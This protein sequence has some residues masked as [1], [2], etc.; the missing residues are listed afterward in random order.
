MYQLVQDVIAYPEFLS[1]C[2]GAEVLEQTSGVQIARL[3]V[4]IGGIRQSFTTHNRLTPDHELS[5][6]LVDG[7]FKRLTGSWRFAPLGT[8]GSKV[9]LALQFEF[10][11]SLLSTAFRSGFARIADKLVYDFSARADAVYGHERG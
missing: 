5:L 9:T 10:S 3:D 1:W 11:N 8:V 6:A 7:P 4:S 2:T